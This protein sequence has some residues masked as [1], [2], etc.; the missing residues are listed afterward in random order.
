MKKIQ[1]IVIVL[2]AGLLSITAQDKKINFNKGTLTIFLKRL[3]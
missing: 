3:F 2:T 1:F